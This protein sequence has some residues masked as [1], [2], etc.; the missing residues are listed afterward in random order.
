M[1]K[2]YRLSYFFNVWEAI[3]TW[4]DAQHPLS[5]CLQCDYNISLENRSKLHF[6]LKTLFRKE[7]RAVDGKP[8][9]E[10]RRKE[11]RDWSKRSSQRFPRHLLIDSSVISI[12]SAITSTRGR[13]YPRGAHEIRYRRSHGAG[14]ARSTRKGACRVPLKFDAL[15]GVFEYALALRFR[16]AVSD[17]DGSVPAIPLR[18]RLFGFGVQYGFQA[19]DK[20]ASGRDILPTRI[21]R[22]RTISGKGGKKITA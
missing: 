14:P 7:S 8:S 5:Q 6:V 13:G 9:P 17:A 3:C 20:S 1:K 12:F 21:F 19:G 18:D 22:C 4:Q 10:K 16:Q 11:Q 15:I 2:W